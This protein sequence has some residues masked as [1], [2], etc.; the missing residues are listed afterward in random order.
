MNSPKNLASSSSPVYG[1]GSS[2]SN[3]NNPTNISVSPNASRQQHG[4][5][6]SSFRLTSQKQHWSIDPRNASIIT[7]NN[8]TVLFPKLLAAALEESRSRPLRPVSV[9]RWGCVMIVDI[10]GFTA[11]TEAMKDSGSAADE[12][13]FHINQYFDLLIESIHKAGGDVIQ[14]CGDALLCVFVGTGEGDL[15]R[16]ARV[17]ISCALTLFY[18][19]EVPISPNHTVTLG[20]HTGIGCGEMELH[21][22]GTSRQGSQFYLSGG[23]SYEAIASVG[24]SARGELAISRT[25]W[26]LVGAGSGNSAQI[27]LTVRTHSTCANVVLVERTDAFVFPGA[28]PSKTKEYSPGTLGEMCMF[29]EACAVGVRGGELRNLTAA[30]IRLTGLDTTEGE[31]DLQA[32]QEAFTTIAEEVQ[33]KEGTINKVLFDDKGLVMLL[34]W[35]TP[36]ATHANDPELAVSCCMT[37]LTN[38]P[39]TIHAGITRRMAFSGACGSKERKEYT[40]LG[41]GV[42]MSSRLMS[43]AATSNP[44]E[45]RVIVDSS[46]TDNL[47]G[48]IVEFAPAVAVTVKGCTEPMNVYRV[49]RVNG[50]KAGSL[51]SSQVSRTGSICSSGLGSPRTSKFRFGQMPNKARKRSFDNN[52]HNTSNNHHDDDLFIEAETAESA[53]NSG[54]DVDEAEP[55]LAIHGRSIEE[56]K[57]EELLHSACTPRIISVKVR[58]GIGHRALLFI[59]DAGL[60]KTCLLYKAYTRAREDGSFLMFAEGVGPVPFSAIATLVVS[61]INAVPTDQV[62][63][64]CVV[65]TGTRCYDALIKA[66]RP[67]VVASKAP[68]SKKTSLASPKSQ[69]TDPDEDTE[70]DTDSVISASFSSVRE[71][72]AVT[73]DELVSA[74]SQLLAF[75]ARFR[76]ESQALAVLDNIHMMDERSLE[77][78]WMVVENNSN[79]CLVAAGMPMDVPLVQYSRHL[80]YTHHAHTLLPLDK[81]ASRSMYEDLLQTNAIERA[82]VDTVYEKSGGNP[83]FAEQILRAGR[84]SGVIIVTPT[85]ASIAPGQSV[86]ALALTDNITNLIVQRFDTLLPDKKVVLKCASVL[87]LSFKHTLFEDL[88]KS[89]VTDMTT[90]RLHDIVDELKESGFFSD[91]RGRNALN[92]TR[93]ATEHAFRLQAVQECIYNLTPVRERRELHAHAAKGLVQSKGDVHAIVRHYVNSCQDKEALRFIDRASRSALRNHRYGEAANY[94]EQSLQLLASGETHHDSGEQMM[95][96]HRMLTQARFFSGEFS[97][98]REA[99]GTMLKEH[100]TTNSQYTV[101]TYSEKFRSL[102]SNPYSKQSKMWIRAHTE[103]YRT[104]AVL[105]VVNDNRRD[106]EFCCMKGS[107]LAC[108]FDGDKDQ[109]YASF[110][111]H[112]PGIFSDSVTQLKSRVQLLG[113][114]KS[115]RGRNSKALWLLAGMRVQNERVVLELDNNIAKLTHGT[116]IASIVT[117]H[118][119]S[120]LFL[121]GEVERLR[122]QSKHVLLYAQKVHDTR[123]ELIAICFS[124]LVEVYLAGVGDSVHL[125]RLLRMLEASLVLRTIPLDVCARQLVSCTQSLVAARITRKNEDAI[126]KA[127]ECVQLLPEVPTMHSFV[128]VVAS[129]V[130]FEV[131]A[132]ATTSVAGSNTQDPISSRDVA[133]CLKK[134]VALLK[135]T[136]SKVP[137][138]F[139]P[140]VTFDAILA[141]VPKQTSDCAARAQRL[142]NA[143]TA[144]A[145]RATVVSPT[146][147]PNTPPS[148]SGGTTDKKKKGK[149]KPGAEREADYSTVFSVLW[150]RVVFA[151]HVGAS[152]ASPFFPSGVLELAQQNLEE[153]GCHGVAHPDTPVTIASTDSRSSSPKSKGSPK[154]PKHPQR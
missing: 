76:G 32:V 36:G 152:K 83:G 93:F 40:A 34:L 74:I 51:H 56:D 24:A 57:I 132:T 67:K 61:A 99:V 150:A 81:E 136:M 116:F 46:I 72:A 28:A 3:S 73:E 52:N 127:Y 98:A 17:A 31:I 114:S 38:L 69:Q 143:I 84:D 122:A 15:P 151:R 100:P 141:F 25:L 101:Q 37:I 10:S 70:T 113:N 154:S 6:F 139:L 55:Q 7:Q 142:V 66:F 117:T 123:L 8:V 1:Q 111:R 95:E 19:R 103:A 126:G 135:N 82:I 105:S 16:V 128:H 4:I 118:A 131:F 26:S 153:S 149:N 47:P 144:I 20:V 86:S 107:L 43:Y 48:D 9:K 18:E 62:R 65:D 89:A 88:V 75:Y 91:S 13:S 148:K 54:T 140:M 33:D 147:D 53:D 145:R 14:F 42:N 92:T 44:D 119:L 78:L 90:E 22:V 94:C 121:T 59:G 108:V 27:S 23:A 21:L 102:C 77:A 58:P 80:L 63:E 133:A 125:T 106:V 2:N 64:L 60:G 124:V 49:M 39:F 129:V 11:A 71:P 68:T 41:S 45:S 134:I 112:M 87:G 120:M 110:F 35:G 85:V 12:I 79:V 29:V 115:L 97:R 50:P 138:A 96:A 5:G 109:D 104:L 146:L 30:F 130:C 137:L